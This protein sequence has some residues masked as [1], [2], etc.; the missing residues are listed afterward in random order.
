MDL[1]FSGLFIVK[2]A[3]AVRSMAIMQSRECVVMFR[4]RMRVPKMTL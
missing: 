2:A 1:A 4:A 3:K